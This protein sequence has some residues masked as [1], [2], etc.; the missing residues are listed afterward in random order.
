MSQKFALI[1][2]EWDFYPVFSDSLST[3]VLGAVIR[4]L[5]NIQ[6]EASKIFLIGPIIATTIGLFIAILM[7]KQV[8]GRLNKMS[9]ALQV[10]DWLMGLPNSI[11]ISMPDFELKGILRV[12]IL[13]LLAIGVYR[14]YK[15]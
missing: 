2:G 3:M 13:V 9:M 11:D 12:I 5:T 1:M 14:Y 4:A 15:D 10:L 6:G 7:L 8:E